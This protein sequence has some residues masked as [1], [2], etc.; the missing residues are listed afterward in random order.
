MSCCVSGLKEIAVNFLDISFQIIEP[1]IQQQASVSKYIAK[2]HHLTQPC[3]SKGLTWMMVV[4][5]MKDVIFFFL[6]YPCLSKVPTEK[7]S[8]KFSNLML[9]ITKYTFTKSKISYTKYKPVLF[10]RNLL[11]RK[12][13]TFVLQFYICNV[14]TGCVEKNFTVSFSIYLVAV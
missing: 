1:R 10:R 2:A 9:I 12:N 5:L 6:S 11:Q 14:C 7:Y 3:S 13:T 8:Y 4:L